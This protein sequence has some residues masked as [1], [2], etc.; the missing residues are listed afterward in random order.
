MEALEQGDFFVVPL[1][2][3]RHWYR[4]HHLFADVLHTHSREEQPDRVATLHRQASEWYEHLGSTADTMT[5]GMHHALAAED[6][7]RTADLVERAVS[8]MRRSRQETT[9]LG[10][11]K[12]LFDEVLHCRP[13]LSVHDTGTLLHRGK[14]ECPV[15]AFCEGVGVRTEA[16]VVAGEHDRLDAELLR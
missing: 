7:E 12:A 14:L 11:L 3:A 8:S 9:L 16:H 10:W 5:Y 1:D 2:D 6:F 15:Q 4:Y 13:V